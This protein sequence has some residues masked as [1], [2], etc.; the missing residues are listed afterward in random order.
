MFDFHEVK[1]DK[2]F[3]NGT[4]FWVGFGIGS[5]FVLGSAAVLT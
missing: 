4:D 5:A 2:L 1:T 3:S